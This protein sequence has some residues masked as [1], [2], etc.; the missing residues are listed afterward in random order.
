MHS[1]QNLGRFTHYI[2]APAT[3]VDLG[4]CDY[5]GGWWAI[6]NPKELSKAVYE[7][8]TQ[9]QTKNCTVYYHRDAL[10]TK[11]YF[12]TDVCWEPIV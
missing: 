7:G 4:L 10:A 5:Q 12:G 11:A 1:N 2:T 9:R 6:E 8:I 3:G